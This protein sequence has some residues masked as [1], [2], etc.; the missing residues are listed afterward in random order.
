MNRADIDV[1]AL[2]YF[3]STLQSFNND[4]ETKWGSLKGRWQASSESW[5]DAKKGQFE[6][7][8]GW[9][10]V[11]KMMDGY[12]ATSEQYTN[13]LK[14]LEERASAYLDA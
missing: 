5:R 10:E 2:R 6:G 7:T 3:I 1:E 14:R 9:D 4:L 8:V 13:F 11:V 12:L